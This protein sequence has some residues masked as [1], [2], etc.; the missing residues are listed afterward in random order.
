MLSEYDKASYDISEY[1]RILNGG[2][3]IP[4]FLI[5]YIK[6]PLLQRLKGIGLLCGTD[7]TPLYKNRFYYSRL[8]HSIGVA[9][10]IYHFTKSKAQTISGLLHDVSTPVFSHVT[11]FRKGD[12]LTQT[13]TET[14]NTYIINSDKELLKLLTKDKIDVEEVSDYHKYP[15]ADNEIPCLSSDR[16]EYMFPSGMALHGSWTLDEI[17][18]IYSDISILKNEQKIDE[19]GFLSVSCAEQYCY[20]FCMTSHVLQLNEN[21]LTLNLLGRIMNLAVEYNLL[22]EKEFMLFSEAEIIKKLSEY[23][24]NNKDELAKLF[25]TFKNMKKIEHTENEIEGHYCINLKVKQRYINP[26][27][28]TKSGNV[29]RLS[30]ISETGKKI[31]DDFKSYTDTAF[32]CVRISD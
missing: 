8:D 31:I 29:K 20:K 6:L 5:P 1:H 14:Q 7:W 13:K 26:L 10:I 16:L 30:E 2:N 4:D 25:R 12:A 15:V 22:K 27:V 32:G 23:E 18:K 21:K 3:S 11:D 19:L 24:Q 9:L 28:K 17:R